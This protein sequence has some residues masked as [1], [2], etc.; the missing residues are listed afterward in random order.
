MFPFRL[1]E[2]GGMNDGLFG[3]GV[4]FWVSVG[5]RCS[6]SPYIVGSVYQETLKGGHALNGCAGND[7]LILIRR[8][9]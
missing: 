3:T 7:L 5:G 9:S 4:Y 8:N 2:E 6:V 1:S